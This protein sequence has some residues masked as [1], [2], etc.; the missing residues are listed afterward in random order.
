MAPGEVLV[1]VFQPQSHHVVMGAAGKAEQEVHE[2]AMEDR[3]MPLY[4]R[5]GGGGTVLLGPETIVVT[6]HAGVAHR[7]KNLAYFQAVNSALIAAMERFNPGPFRQ[8]GISDIA[9]GELKVV[10]TSIYRKREYLLYQASVLYDLNLELMN[11]V[12]KHPPKEPDYRQ[13]RSHG[14][15][16]TSLSAL[17]CRTP[18]PEIVR[19][20][21]TFLPAP[22][23]EALK[24]ADALPE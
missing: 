20:W 6:V 3:Q 13:G 7:F 23:A 1:E 19:D 15:F 2:S 14:A 24:R 4:K 22:V 5:K 16:L 9:Q 17:G 12:L 21:L 18:I 11:Q 10:G 8:R